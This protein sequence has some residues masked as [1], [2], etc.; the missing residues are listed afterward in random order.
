MGDFVLICLLI[1]F[2]TK[3]IIFNKNDISWWK[4]LIP[5]YSIYILGKI[6][7][8]KKIKI[9]N[10]ILLPLAYL[11]FIACYIF[12]LWIIRNYSVLVRVPNGDTYSSDIRVEV[13]SWVANL[14]L[15]S[16]YILIGIFLVSIICWSIMMYK[17]TKYHR[18][19]TWWIV[20]WAIIPA[21]PYSYFAISNR[22]MVDGKPARIEK[23][24]K[25]DRK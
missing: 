8:V 12:E 17:F 18:R 2:I 21:I 1:C 9:V 11:Y 14:S 25:Y 13:P 6:G 4:G 7:N 24:I 15:T 16:K 5:G 22:I 20:A 10:A 23:V 19:T 3:C